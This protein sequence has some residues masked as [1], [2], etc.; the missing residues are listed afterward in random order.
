MP[1][2]TD[3]LLTTGLPTLIL[4]ITT[5]VAVLAGV[6]LNSA[7]KHLKAAMR[8]RDEANELVVNSARQ[9]DE[10]RND[11]NRCQKL[12]RE[13]NLQLEGTKKQLERQKETAAT[14]AQ[15]MATLEITHLQTKRENDRMLEFITWF[16]RKHPSLLN[17]RTLEEFTTDTGTPAPMSLEVRA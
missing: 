7:R 5:A 9:A 10:A 8:Y 1:P 15:T 4:L 17:R 2:T 14:A 6:L 3:N 13:T 16:S 11:A 12:N